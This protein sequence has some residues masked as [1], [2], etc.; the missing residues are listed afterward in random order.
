MIATGSSRS[1]V[2]PSPSWPLPLSPQ[3]HTAPSCWRA[4]VCSSPVGS[5]NRI[6]ADS[7]VERRSS[8][9]FWAQNKRNSAELSA[10][11]GGP[12]LI[13][14]AGATWRAGDTCQRL[15]GRLLV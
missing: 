5:E 14:A 4:T 3:A 8:V 15:V 1:V 11:D 12:A 9:R 10:M 13:L 6:G 2:V 7:L